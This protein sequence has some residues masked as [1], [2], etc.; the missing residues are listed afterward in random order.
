MA[1]R[2]PRA[3]RP[4]RVRRRMPMQPWFLVAAVLALAL[5]GVFLLWHRQRQLIYFPSQAVPP[6]A[7]V[8]D[9]A[10]EVA[11]DTADGLRL[12]GWFVPPVGEPR[13]LTVLVL[14]GNG[15][16][17]AHRAPL[18]AALSRAGLAVLLFD[19]RGYGGNPGTPTETG[20]LADARAAR[21][22][23]A[24]RPDV[25]P[26]RL[27]YLGES[28]GTAVAVALAVEQPPLALV[29][30]SPF[31]SLVDLGRR[32]YPALPVGLLLRDRYPSLARIGRAAAPL[33]VVAGERDRLVPVAQSRRLYEAAGEPKRFVLIAGADHNDDALLAGE[34]FIGE[35]VR[36]LHDAAGGGAGVTR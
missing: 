11:F 25:D 36:F 8:L 1:G 10:Q 35:V 32:H 9:G 12:A 14:N 19:Y 29:L 20:L 26:G 31:T 7:A 28:L 21:A 6:A 4:S 2:A 18:A 16:N 27:V 5:L 3:A 24:A 15:G 23:L 13:G 30:R 33:L 17:R 34:R 22:Y